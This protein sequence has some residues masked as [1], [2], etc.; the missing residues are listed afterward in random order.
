M[1]QKLDDGRVMKIPPVLLGTLGDDK[2]KPTVCIYGHLDVQP[3]AK[4]DGWDSQPFVL[5]QV[6]GKLFGRGSSDDKG[7]VLAW[8]H[9]IES[10]RAL[11]EEL[12]VNVKVRQILLSLSFSSVN[13]CLPIKN[14]VFINP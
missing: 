6:D 9:A 8:L 4:E 14:E 13:V 3:A 1:F 2:K 5:T 10:Y 11:G 7:P 12:P